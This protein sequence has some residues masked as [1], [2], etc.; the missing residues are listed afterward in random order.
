MSL[1]FIYKKTEGKKKRK[2]ERGNRFY[3]PV[4]QP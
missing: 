2:K 1:S 3:S 4:S